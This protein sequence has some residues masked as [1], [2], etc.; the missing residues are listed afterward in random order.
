MQ[1]GVTADADDIEAVDTLA[2]QLEKLNPNPKTL[3]SPLV[4]GK[5]KVGSTDTSQ[6]TGASAQRKEA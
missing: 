1:R 6:C 4:N 2:R 5:W 3:A